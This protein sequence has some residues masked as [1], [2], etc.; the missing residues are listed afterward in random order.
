[1]VIT[2]SGHAYPWDVLGD[3][4]FADRV[5]GQGVATVTLAAAYHSA[6]AATPLHPRHQ[7]V[8]AG[9]AALYRPVRESVWRSRRLR[10]WSPDWMSEDD[11]FGAAAHV[12]RAAG[13]RVGAWI[14]LTHNTGLGSVFGELAVTN[15]VG[16]RYP[17]ALCPA[18]PEVRDYAAMLAAESVAEAPVDEVSLEACGQLGLAHNSH[19]E[20]TEGAWTPSAMRWL[21]VCCCAACKSAWRERGLD[22]AEVVVTLRA[23]VRAEAEGAAGTVPD[24]MAA[25]LLAARH[26]AADLLRAEVLDQLAL[27]APDVAVVLH[28]HPDPWVTGPSPGLTASAAGQVDAVLV[29]AWPTDPATADVVAAAAKAGVPVDAYVTV[30]P[31]TDPAALGSHVRRLVTAGAGRLSLYH[32]GLAP[33]WRQPLFREVVDLVGTLTKT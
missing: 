19:H 9:Y 5:A 1:M 11:P 20:K 3:P 28:A 23:A 14:V 18:Q 30:L 25:E 13:L 29:P 33:R 2:V 7:L 22:P 8:D 17:Y 32:L 12:L 21:S 4:A 31:P 16:D 24:Q 15:C 10:P 26:D 6:R 27:H